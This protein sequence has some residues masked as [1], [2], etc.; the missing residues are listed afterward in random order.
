MKHWMKQTHKGLLNAGP[1]HVFYL[2]KGLV[3][4][5][6][7]QNIIKSVSK[8]CSTMTQLLIECLS[9]PGNYGTHIGKPASG[10]NLSSP[11]LC[12]ALPTS[13]SPDFSD[14]SFPFLSHKVKHDWRPPAMPP[15]AAVLPFQRAFLRLS[16]ALFRHEWVRGNTGDK[17]HNLSGHSQLPGMRSTSSPCI[18]RHNGLLG[19][20]STA[21]PCL[22]RRSRLP[23]RRSTASPPLQVLPTTLDE[24]H[25]LSGS[26]RLPWVRSTASLGAPDYL[27]R[28]AQPLQASPGNPDY[29]GRGSR[30]LRELPTTL[31]EEHSLSGHSP[32][33]RMRS[34]ASPGAPH[35]PEWGATPLQVLPTILS[36]RQTPHLHVRTVFYLTV[37][38]KFKP[39][40][41]RD[42]K[43]HLRKRGH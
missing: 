35:Y 6:R 21:S 9:E 10:N 17:E 34:T 13:L 37:P 33:P 38:I 30:P 20:R 25:G 7:K 43:C 11:S 29:P 14:Y 22:S 1:Y 8:T 39:S 42:Y 12:L 16:T 27:R 5:W 4:L 23:G 26:S 41:H 15:S 31:G 28:G 24:E 36:Q 18:S 2:C 40:Y 3:S 32:L 19:T